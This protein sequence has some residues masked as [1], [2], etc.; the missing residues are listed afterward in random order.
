MTDDLYGIAPKMLVTVALKLGIWCPSIIDGAAVLGTKEFLAT[1]GPIYLELTTAL[2]ALGAG[3]KKDLEVQLK[4]CCL[5]A[6]G[7]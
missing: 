2:V 1:K 7:V 3:P 6:A 4:F 5:I